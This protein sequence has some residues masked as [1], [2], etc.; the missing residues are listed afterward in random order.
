MEEVIE[1]GE[2]EEETEE[3]I[4]G[5]ETIEDISTETDPETTIVITEMVEEVIGI[6]EI[7][8]IITEGGTIVIIHHDR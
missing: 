4:G 2:E 6:E 3:I 1:A 5:T 8:E 7:T